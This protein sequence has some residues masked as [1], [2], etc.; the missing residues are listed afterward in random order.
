M[1]LYFDKYE[2]ILCGLCLRSGRE[3][4]LW[5]QSNRNKMIRPMER[6]MWGPDP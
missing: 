2:G 4:S 5:G 1:P 3:K 6:K